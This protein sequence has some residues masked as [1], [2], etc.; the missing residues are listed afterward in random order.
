[1]HGRTVGSFARYTT[2]SLIFEQASRSLQG[3]PVVS[4]R[5]AAG[6]PSRVAQERGERASGAIGVAVRAAYRTL[7]FGAGSGIHLVSG[8]WNSLVAP[9]VAGRSWVLEPLAIF[10]VS[11]FSF[12]D[13]YVLVQVHENI[14]H[15][16][17][18]GEQMRI[19]VRVEPGSLVRVRCRCPWFHVSLREARM[20]A[21]GK[22]IPKGPEV[23]FSTAVRGQKSEV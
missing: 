5:P 19:A 4:Y 3:S 9:P 17:G 13:T 14:V 20:K 6:A 7:H 16:H 23:Y 10:A 15:V 21:V 2:I 12:C 22:I 1:M 11:V 8:D 18:H